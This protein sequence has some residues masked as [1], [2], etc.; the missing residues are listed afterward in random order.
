MTD[1]GTVGTP[2][3]LLNKTIG[4]RLGGPLN[5][6]Q[7]VGGPPLILTCF[8]LCETDSMDIQKTPRAQFGHLVEDTKLV[9]QDLFSLTC[10]RGMRV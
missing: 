9:E 6:W 2:T 10:G 3:C 8:D 1:K 5:F 7:K 4:K